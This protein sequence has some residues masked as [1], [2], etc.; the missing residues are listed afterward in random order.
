MEEFMYPE[1]WEINSIFN[2]SSDSV[3]IHNHLNE[4]DQEVTKLEVLIGNTEDSVDGVDT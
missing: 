3:V 4:I 1:R 2:V